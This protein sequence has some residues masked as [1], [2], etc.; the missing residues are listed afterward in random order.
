VEF[1]SQHVFPLLFGV[2][3]LAVLILIV[4]GSINRASFAL[5]SA[6]GFTCD[7]VL[8]R[9]RNQPAGWEG[10]EFDNKDICQ[11]TGVLLER[12]RTY[13]V[14]ITLPDD[15][16][17]ASHK[18]GLTGFG[19]SEEAI[20]YYPALP[21]RRVLREPWFV[22]MARIGR[23]SPEYYALSAPVTEV[24]PRRTGHLYLFVNDAVGLPPW[25]DY[26][27]RNNRGAKAIV[28]VRE[29]GAPAPALAADVNGQR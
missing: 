6:A 24:T 10:I 1:I 15:W 23:R 26:F 3:T 19:S 14:S 25:R 22:P 18:A 20:V 16:A 4:V 21:F 27:Y 29:R 7:R 17:D 11:A 5:A 12:G 8:N 28:T 2:T 9:E 13:D